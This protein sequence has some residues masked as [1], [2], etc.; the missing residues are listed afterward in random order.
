MN[1]AIKND[2]IFIIKIIKIFKYM[3]EK[4]IKTN[5]IRQN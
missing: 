5:S 1:K 4:L 2:F 3:Q